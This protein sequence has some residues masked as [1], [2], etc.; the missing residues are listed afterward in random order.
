MKNIL[1]LA[2]I[3]LKILQNWFK[4][5]KSHYFWQIWGLEARIRYTIK[6]SNT[7]DILF[8]YVMFSYV[9]WCKIVWKIHFCAYFVKLTPLK[10]WKLTLNSKLSYRQSKNELKMAK[11]QKGLTFWFGDYHEVLPLSFLTQESLVLVLVEQKNI[12]APKASCVPY[13]SF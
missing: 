10:W 3:F 11:T 4:K 7:F 1:S 2:G 8:F 9:F 5:G 13:G 12:F 6:V